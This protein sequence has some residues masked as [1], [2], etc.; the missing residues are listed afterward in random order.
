V[1]N[2]PNPTDNRERLA[3]IQHSRRAPKDARKD[4]TEYQAL[5]GRIRQENNLVRETLN[6]GDP[7]EFGHVAFR[8]SARH[9]EQRR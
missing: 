3:L 2:S 5:I 4:S 7:T 8:L 6:D 1:P 9:H